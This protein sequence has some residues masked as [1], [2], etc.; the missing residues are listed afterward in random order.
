MDRKMNEEEHSNHAHSM[1]SKQ[2]RTVYL[3]RVEKISACHRLHSNHLSDEENKKIYGKCNNPNGHGHNYTV[4]VTLKGKVD[5]VTGMVINITDL[6]EYMKKAIMDTLDHKNIDLDVPYFK[7]IVSTTENVATYI[8]DQMTQLLPDP[9]LLYEV[10]I[11]ETDKNI[12]F[13]RGE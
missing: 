10:K 2:G 3:S 1:G 7:D 13:Y 6:K 11:H 12:V 8:W 4:T 5:P 9:S